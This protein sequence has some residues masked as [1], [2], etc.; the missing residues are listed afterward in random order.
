[1]GNRDRGDDG[2]ALLIGDELAKHYPKN[3]FSTE[4]DDISVFLL[5]I[6]DNDDFEHVVLIDAADFDSKPGS[7]LLSSTVNFKIKSIST[8]SIPYNQIELILKERKKDFTLIGI[9]VKSLEFMGKITNEVLEASKKII[10][11][12]VLKKSM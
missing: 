3:V 1:M 5:H 8:H 12:F 7:V 9:Q 10:D 4:E 11:L 6:I 2:V